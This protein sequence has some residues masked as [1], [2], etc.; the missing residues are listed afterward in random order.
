MEMMELVEP[1]KRVKPL[2]SMDKKIPQR[3]MIQY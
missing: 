1:M 3:Q 2:N